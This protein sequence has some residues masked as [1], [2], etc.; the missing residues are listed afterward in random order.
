MTE[1]KILVLYLLNSDYNS[2]GLLGMKIVSIFNV[3]IV[4]LG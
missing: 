1:V 3:S 2:V 4:I